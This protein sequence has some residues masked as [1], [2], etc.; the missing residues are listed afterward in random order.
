MTEARSLPTTVRTSCTRDCPDACGIL[1]TV[2]DERVV[3]LQ[4][5]PEHPIT[6]GFLCYR[7]GTHFLSRQ[8]SPE[9]LTTPWMRHGDELVPI[10]WDTALDFAAANLW[11]I[12]DE[13]GGAAIL[14]SQ[15]GGSLGILKN[16]NGVFSRHLGATETCGDVC[17]GAGSYANEADFGTV[18]SNAL[19]DI[20]NARTI[21]IWG[22]NP[23]NSS[24][25]TTPFLNDAKRAGATIFAIDPLATRVKSLAHHVLSPRPGGDAALALGVCLA[26]IEQ[27]GVHQE[28]HD[29]TENL[30]RFLALVN[31]RS[32]HEWAREADVSVEAIRD[33]AAHFVENAPVTTLV[34][35][36]LQ[37]R[38]NGAT[39]I[40]AIDA[41]HALT[42]NLGRPGAGASF[43]TTRRRPFD[44]SMKNELAARVPRALPIALLG[45]A[46]ES[47][48]DPAIRAVIVDNHNP[49]ATNPDSATT[50]RA[51][52]SREFTLVLDSFLT[53]TARCAHLVLPT[54]TMLEEDDLIGSYGHH[55]V[56]A[57]RAVATRLPGT[58]TDLE[59]YQA[60]AERMGF[61][62]A[63]AGTPERW[64]ERMIGKM[65]PHGVT[66]DSLRD[67]SRRDPSSSSIAFL[68]RRFATPSGR[69]RFLDEYRGPR[70]FDPEFPLHF[71]ALSTGRW[72]AS[73]LTEADEDR[74]GPLVVSAHPAACLG[75]ADGDEAWLESRVGR[76]RVVVRHDSAYRED[77][78]YA[79][80]ARSVRRGL[81]VNAIIAARETDFGGGAAYYDEPVRLRS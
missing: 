12:R 1:A 15:G 24:P 52:R 54:T 9:R 29:Y 36:G 80:R 40:R 27:G 48:R 67:A 49:V 20:V 70:A 4:G 30:D 26:V 72:Q 68:G 73:Q 41:L 2:E 74:E 8:Y 23:A 50:A 81:C 22:K 28:I 37:R 43:G 56:S 77:T 42:G 47:A 18:E 59:I 35:W 25:H 5:D 57:S 51:L 55:H 46:I 65:T 45:E 16:L 10:D 31:S 21:V 19:E 13:S 33:L 39:Q 60:L 75:I 79:P 34:G 63:L 38:G 14:H 69:F 78:I 7:I 61:G 3:R 71:Q 64:M 6:R 58:R 76:L 32:I 53:D 62:D 66:L 11:R 17:D 44:L